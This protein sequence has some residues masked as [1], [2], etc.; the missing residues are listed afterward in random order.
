MSPA[1]RAS[2]KHA[3]PHS[4]LAASCRSTVRRPT[5]FV[6]EYQGLDAVSLADWNPPFPIDLKLIRDQDEAYWKQ[7][8][9]TP[10]AFVSLADGQRLWETRRPLRANHLD[11][12]LAAEQWRHDKRRRSA[13]TRGQFQTELPRHLNAAELGLRFQ[14]TRKQVLQAA[15]G[16]TDFGVLFVLQFLSHLAAAMLVALLFRLGVERLR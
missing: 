1:I 2:S 10:K 8:R 14:S 12:S 5:R 7:Y 15:T 6:P 16:N 4:R 13:R 9:T 11:P 3:R